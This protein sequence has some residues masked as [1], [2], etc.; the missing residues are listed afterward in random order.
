[1]ARL[2]EPLTRVADLARKSL[3]GATIK[4]I[5]EAYATEGW[6]C[7]TAAMEALSRAGTAV[8]SALVGNV[9]MAV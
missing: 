6:R 1:M 9:L 5:A 2:L 3:G 4:A 8:D 7:D